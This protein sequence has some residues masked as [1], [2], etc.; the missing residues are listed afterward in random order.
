MCLG[1]EAGCPAEPA[2]QSVGSAVSSNSRAQILQVSTSSS[3]V[4]C[5]L[6]TAHSVLTAR[7]QIHRPTMSSFLRNR[8]HLGCNVISLSQ[9]ILNYLVI[10]CIEWVSLM[11]SNLTLAVPPSD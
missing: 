3:N 1:G 7:H 10:D 6:H 8:V 2:L 5:T 9:R 11:I 4:Q